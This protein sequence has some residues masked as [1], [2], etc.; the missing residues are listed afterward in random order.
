MKLYHHYIP[1]EKMVGAKLV[2]PS[3]LQRMA[4]ELTEQHLVK[5]RNRDW[6]KQR[7][8]VSKV[9]IPCLSCTLVDVIQMV[10]IPV[11]QI[12]ER[13][14]LLG[15]TPLRFFEIESDSLDQNCLCAY[16]RNDEKTGEPIY[17]AFD[18]SLPLDQVADAFEKWWRE[19]IAKGH[20]RR[21]YA[22]V[23]HIYYKGEI[24]ITNCPV[25]S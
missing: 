9:Q 23:P 25:V 12:Q 2:P 13:Q 16:Y 17:D 22:G 18:P 11:S 20:P 15:G 1:P 3:T 10:A 6:F 8:G 21:I 7:G 4:P 5:Y 19:E 14:R 24:D